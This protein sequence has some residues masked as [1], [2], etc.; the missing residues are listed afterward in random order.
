MDQIDKY[1]RVEEDQLQGKGKEK[2]IL[3]KKSDFKSDQ[4]NYN[5]SRRDF[6][7]QSGSTN[8][9]TVSTVF[10]ESVH[11]VLEKIKNE[12]FF[13]WSNKM[14][15]DSM[16]RNQS[17]YCQYHQDYGHTIEDYRNL[18]NH[19]DQLVQEGKLRH[20]LHPSNGHQG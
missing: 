7:R 10:K 15:G 18:C 19:L 11:Q 3:Q 6:A 14:A 1:K 2:V 17:L 8:T 9:Q 12:P 13:K 20:F 16:K 5:L 4:Y